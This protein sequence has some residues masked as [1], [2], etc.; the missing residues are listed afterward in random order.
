M[1]FQVVKCSEVKIIVEMAFHKSKSAGYKKLHQR[2]AD[3]YVGLSNRQVLKCSSTNEKIRKFSVKFTIEAKPSPVI[4]KRI[5]QQ[6]QV[7]LVDMNG[8]QVSFMGKHIGTFCQLWICSL[9][10]IG[11]LPLKKRRVVL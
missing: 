10:F 3:G 2:K 5:H 9:G 6:H 7:D 8:M 1:E 11:W 4:V